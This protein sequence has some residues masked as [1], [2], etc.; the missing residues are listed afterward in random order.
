MWNSTI[1][2]NQAADVSIP[3]RSAVEKLMHAMQAQGPAGTRTPSEMHHQCTGMGTAQPRLL[4]RKSSHHCVHLAH[5]AHLQHQPHNIVSHQTRRCAQA[6]RPVK[7]QTRYMFLTGI[8][9]EPHVSCVTLHEMHTSRHRRC[10]GPCSDKYCRKQL[11]VALLAGKQLHAR[12]QVVPCIT[13][14]GYIE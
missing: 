7:A 14:S 6:A 13:D 1:N 8:H 2:S 5:A 11:R 9:I 10:H 3:V 4:L 12:P